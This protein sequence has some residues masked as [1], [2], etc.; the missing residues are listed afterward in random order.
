MDPNTRITLRSLRNKHLEQIIDVYRS[1]GMSWSM[2]VPTAVEV[3]SELSDQAEYELRPTGADISKMIL[4]QR[5]FK[6][7]EYLHAYITYNRH[8]NAPENA[9]KLFDQK[10]REHFIG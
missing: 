4:T 8:A 5:E 3:R 2:E 7:Q 10:M 6:G 9:D 1:T